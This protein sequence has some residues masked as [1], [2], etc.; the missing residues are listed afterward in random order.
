MDLLV[1]VI[2]LLGIVWLLI[3]K[4]DSPYTFKSRVSCSSFQILS[5]GKFYLMI[6]LDHK[7]LTALSLG[8]WLV[9]SNTEELWT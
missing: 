9:E 7:H 3:D 8:L 5:N 2:A 6:C 1:E 4:K